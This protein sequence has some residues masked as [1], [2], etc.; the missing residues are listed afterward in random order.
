MEKT[1]KT[2]KLAEIADRIH[3][4]LKEHESDN[5][6]NT[7]DPKYG[8][9]KLYFPRCTV[10]GSKVKIVPEALEYLEWLDAGNK[11]TYYECL[12][13]KGKRA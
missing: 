4:H 6:Y 12:R 8:T 2:P 9:S 5:A 10:A 13:S 7:L 1:E 3:K 11:G